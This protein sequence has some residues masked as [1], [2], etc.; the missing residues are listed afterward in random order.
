MDPKVSAALENTVMDTLS[1]LAVNV[2][3]CEGVVWQ[4]YVRAMTQVPVSSTSKN[5]TALHIRRIQILLGPERGDGTGLGYK[6]NTAKSTT[7]ATELASADTAAPA[8]AP[9]DN[10]K[11]PPSTTEACDAESKRA[12]T[13]S[14]WTRAIHSFYR[15]MERS[16]L[17]A[18]DCK[19]CN[20]APYTA[21]T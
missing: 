19:K 16:W 2:P 17:R 12:R 20:T 3:W 18:I 4:Y 10:A 15:N 13:G 21:H 9:N 5:Q 7:D 14:Q 6:N 11:R 8:P 1:K